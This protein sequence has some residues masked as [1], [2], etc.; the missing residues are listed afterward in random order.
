[1]RQALSCLN[2]WLLLWLVGWTARLSHGKDLCTAASSLLDHCVLAWDFNVTKPFMA[3]LAIQIY[4]YM[5]TSLLKTR[6]LY[7][8]GL[9]RSQD[10]TLL[11][12][13]P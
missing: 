8:D 4:I 2:P 7:W 3:P 5:G 12:D 9:A 11:Q 1:M 13:R 6:R 10:H